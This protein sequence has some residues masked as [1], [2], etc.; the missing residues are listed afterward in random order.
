M[1]SALQRATLNTEI[2]K[3][4]DNEPTQTTGIMLFNYGNYQL[5]LTGTMTDIYSNKYIP[6]WFLSLEQ[7]TAD[8]QILSLTQLL[9]VKTS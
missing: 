7:P 4:E 2:K 5:S 9:Q 8:S 1:D 6:L 3:D